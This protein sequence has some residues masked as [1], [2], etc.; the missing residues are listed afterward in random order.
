M[1]GGG[2]LQL[3]L[4]FCPALLLCRSGTQDREWQPVQ[5]STDKKQT[6]SRWPHCHPSPALPAGHTS[7]PSKADSKHLLK[8]Q[9]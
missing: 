3:G 1:G 5:C 2:H 4:P 6:L 9:H 7:A 8:L